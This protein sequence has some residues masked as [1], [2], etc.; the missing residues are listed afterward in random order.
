M[1]TGVDIDQWQG[2]IGLFHAV[3]VPRN[4]HRGQSGYENF[5]IL[6]SLVYLIWY[7]WRPLEILMWIFLLFSYC[8]MFVICF[9]LYLIMFYTLGYLMHIALLKA[10]RNEDGILGRSLI[11]ALFAVLSLPERMVQKVT[12]AKCLLIDMPIMYRNALFYLFILKI[13][14]IMSGIEQNPGPL[15][16]R[17][18]QLSFAVWNLDSLPARDYARVPLIDA[19][20]S[21]HSF[22]IFGVCES[23]LNKDIGNDDIYTN[24]FSA[25][26]FRSGKPEYFR[27]GAVC[28]YY[29]D[30][31]PLIEIKDL[32]TP[33]ETI[34]AEIRI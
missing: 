2:N 10:D 34:V 24:G 33:P 29:K 22:D 7:L 32:V 20:Q 14:L 9:P 1:M 25:D 4:K 30:H 16:L 21:F 5:S 23:F 15:N 28:L 3:R 26:V 8:F 6:S 11:S 27:N 19:F 12:F 31:L 17:E 13:L 18:S